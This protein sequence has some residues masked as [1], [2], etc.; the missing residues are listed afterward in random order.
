MEPSYVRAFAERFLV[1]KEPVPLALVVA[2][3]ACGLRREPCDG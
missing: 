1:G 3:W 2:R